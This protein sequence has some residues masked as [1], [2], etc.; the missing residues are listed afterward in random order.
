M[1]YFKGRHENIHLEHG[2]SFGMPKGVYFQLA[3]AAIGA[4]ELG[5]IEPQIL[6]PHQDHRPGAVLFLWGKKWSFFVSVDC[7]IDPPGPAF[8]LRAG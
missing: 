3:Q 8:G 4:E 6:T 2:Q 7:S 1:N 5:G